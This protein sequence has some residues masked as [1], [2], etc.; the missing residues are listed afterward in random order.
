M[1]TPSPH[2]SLHGEGWLLQPEPAPC[3][4]EPEPSLKNQACSREAFLVQASLAKRASDA[5]VLLPL[6]PEGSSRPSGRRT[7]E[8]VPVHSASQ[9]LGT[10]ASGPAPA[11]PVTTG[12]TAENALK[13]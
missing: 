13:H 7:S 1:P 2:T 12:P 5:R 9:K 10:S 11:A 4:R 8:E 6:R 3:K